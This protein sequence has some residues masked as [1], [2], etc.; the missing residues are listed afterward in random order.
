M[1]FH[2][3]LALFLETVPTTKNKNK[4][5]KQVCNH[6]LFVFGINFEENNGVDTLLFYAMLKNVINCHAMWCYDI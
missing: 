5:I 6:I 3:F 4:K 1:K 2:V